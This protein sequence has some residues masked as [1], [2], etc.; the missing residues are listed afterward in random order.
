MTMLDALSLIGV[1]VYARPDV[2][3]KLSGE[4][5][6]DGS[7][8][9]VAMKI[10]RQRLMRAMDALVLHRRSTRNHPQIPTFS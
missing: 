10:A 2:S 6:S 8:L 5:C 4:L 9:L 1:R 3:A 7:I